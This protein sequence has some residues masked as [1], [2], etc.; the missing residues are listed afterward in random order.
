MPLCVAYYFGIIMKQQENFLIAA[1]TYNKQCDHIQ[2]L[3]D[4]VLLSKKVT[5][6]K[7]HAHTKEETHEVTEHALAD[8]YDKQ[9]A[10]HP[11]LTDSTNQRLDLI[12]QDYFYETLSKLQLKYQTLKNKGY[13]EKSGCSLHQTG[14]G[15]CPLVCPVSLE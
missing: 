1:G 12:T 14:Y 7:V 10:S 11:S 4:I 5:V 6:I 9:S 15:D 3:L 13:W 8:Q 2:V